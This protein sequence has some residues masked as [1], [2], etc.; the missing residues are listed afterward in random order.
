MQNTPKRQILEIIFVL[1]VLLG[2]IS[3]LVITPPP[4]TRIYDCSIAEISPDYPIDVKDGCR[5]LRAENFN[6]DLQKPK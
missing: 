5:K 3:F 4:K 1:S 6:K 2:S